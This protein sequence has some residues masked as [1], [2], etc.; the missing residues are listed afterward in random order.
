MSTTKN[1]PRPELTTRQVEN[2]NRRLDYLEAR[3]ADA[4]HSVR[5]VKK[6]INRPTCTIVH[7]SRLVADLVTEVR[8]FEH[9]SSR[10]VD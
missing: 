2:A 4:I 5:R 8:R 3:L 7:A 1:R 6:V 9:D 10:I